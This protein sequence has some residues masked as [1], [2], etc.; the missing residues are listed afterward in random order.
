MRKI[1]QALSVAGAMLISAVPAQASVIAFDQGLDTSFAPFAPL[2]THYDALVEGDYFIGTVSTKL[3]ATSAADLV[4][5][6]VDG[7]D[8]GS[9]C[10]GVVCPTNNSTRFMA[11]LN[12]GLPWLARL[13][14]GE[15]QLGSFDASFI[16]AEGD[17]VPSIAMIL[18]VYGF[19]ADGGQFFEDFYL[20]GPVNGGYSFQGF[21]AQGALAGLDVVEL[22]FYGYACN[23][24]G[25][26]SR[27]ADKAQFAL[28]NI[29]LID[30][31]SQVPEPGS[32]ALVGLA[33]AGLA[34]RRFR[35][36]VKA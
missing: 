4:G 15:F 36:P 24:A 13:D 20:P 8:V 5:A 34:G 26:C 23:S 16:A 33:L 27:S 1:L 25:S 6:L 10:F 22:D 14:S 35:S 28:D 3:G 21:Q 17:I 31:T 12:D 29:T 7:T 19:T 2:L 30:S 9:T 11:A 18:R 32:L